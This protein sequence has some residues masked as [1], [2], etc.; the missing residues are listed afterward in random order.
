MSSRLLLGC[1]GSDAVPPDDLNPPDSNGLRL[2]PGVTSRIVALSGQEPVPGSGYVW[3]PAPDGGATFPTDDG[4]WVYVSNSEMDAGQGG[5]GALRFDARGALSDAYS[6]LQGTTRNCAGGATPWHTWLS[7]EEIRKGLVWECQPLGRPEDAV[8]HPALGVFKHE[9][10]AVDPATNQLYMT[11]DEPDG[12]FYRFTP[13]SPGMPPDLSAGT[14]E[15]AQV[16]EGREGAV[17]WHAVADPLAEATSTR[18]QVRASTA[19]DGG[20]GIAYHNGVIYITTKG[21]NRVWAYDIVRRTSA[22]Y[23]T[24]G[25]K[26]VRATAGRTGTSMACSISPR[27]FRGRLWGSPTHN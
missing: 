18:F 10:V 27:C 14:L 24:T 15:V 4:G 2:P 23:Q 21:D 3:H 17:T 8:T 1:A 5:V 12:C 26:L 11:E 19:F 9:A 7:C 20:E 22:G 6:I 25:G 16:T 13:A